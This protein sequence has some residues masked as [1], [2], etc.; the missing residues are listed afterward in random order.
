MSLKDAY[1]GILET[2]LKIAKKLSGEGL[3][4][5]K[6]DAFNEANGRPI[7][8]GIAGNIKGE[9]HIIE[10][11]PEYI[12]KAQ[13]IGGLKVS[14]QDIR[15][16]KYDTETF[17]V[18]MDFSTIDHVRDW[19]LVLKEYNRVLK[20]GGT[21]SII[22]WAKP[23]LEYEGGQFYFPEGSFEKDFQKYFRLKSKKVLYSDHHKL[24]QRRLIHLVGGKPGLLPEIKD[25]PKKFAPVGQPKKRSVSSKG[26]SKGKKTKVSKK[27]S[28][29]NV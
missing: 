14:R 17:D 16:I 6:T 29:K 18:V 24:Y 27:G 25:K 1:Q 21:A 2:Y 4:I 12:G 8:G 13:L 28:K 7:E 20:P 22:Y 15:D 3:V 26:V 5:L 9:I 10:I 11:R 23:A 19:R